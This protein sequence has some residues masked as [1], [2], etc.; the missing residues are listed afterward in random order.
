[1]DRINF[2]NGS[3]NIATN[4]FNYYDNSLSSPNMN[5]NFI[6]YDSNNS[7]IKEMENYLN[8]L[9][10]NNLIEVMDMFKETITMK[11][12]KLRLLFGAKVS[13]I[14]LL[15]R[16]FGTYACLLPNE[17]L[18]LNTLDIEAEWSRIEDKLIV[19]FTELDPFIP[20]DILF[21]KQVLSDEPILIKQPHHQPE[22]IK[23]YCNIFLPSQVEINDLHEK[24]HKIYFTDSE[25][26]ITK[27]PELTQALSSIIFKDVL[28]DNLRD[29]GLDMNKEILALYV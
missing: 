26:D 11:S 9:F 29:T 12:R 25:L 10:P 21:I 3:Y 19:G 20:L 1:M 18:N 14:K 7:S 4:K 15:I 28:I 6:P 23:P 13:F 5:R 17:V 24:V 27:I 8:E 16:T 2:L 22:L